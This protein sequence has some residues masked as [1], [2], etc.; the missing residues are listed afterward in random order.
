MGLHLKASL[1]DKRVVAQTISKINQEGE[2]VSMIEQYRH[3]GR[4]FEMVDPLE[5]H[6]LLNSKLAA[7]EVDDIL[8]QEVQDIINGM[9]DVANGKGHDSKDTRQVVGLAASQVGINARIILIDLSANGANQPQNLVAII[10]PELADLSDELVDGREGCWSCGNVC[11]NVERSKTVTLSGLD[12]YGNPV[13]YQLSD[14]VARVAQHETNHL[15]GI[16]FPDQIPK[17]QPRRLHYVLPEQFELYRTEWP[18]W[19][20]L[21]ERSYWEDFKH[22]KSK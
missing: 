11:G 18:T 4:P 1:D 16:R 19:Q 10:N 13:S 17:D 12:K 21:C 7:V 6:G 2:I 15:D 22:G 14:F 20:T 8:K 9:F 5:Y 3:N